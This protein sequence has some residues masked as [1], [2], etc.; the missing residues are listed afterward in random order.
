MN[1]FRNSAILGT[2][3]LIAGLTS[4]LEGSQFP[5]E[6]EIEFISTVFTDSV[7]L[8]GNQSFIGIITLGF[9]D[10]DGDIG[11]RQG[12]TTKNMFVFQVGIDNGQNQAPTNLSYGIPFVTPSGQN[13][14]IKG[15]IDVE[16][17]IPNPLIN[18]YP[19]DSVFFEIYI[20]DRGKNQSNMI[21][22]PS[23]WLGNI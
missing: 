17:N 13:K 8:L 11:I 6:P 21:T 15:E 19:Y 10:G 16:I 1:L 4:C 3:L 14:N 22:T 7:D 2:A 18:P 12:D 20:E 9:T 23:I 5:D